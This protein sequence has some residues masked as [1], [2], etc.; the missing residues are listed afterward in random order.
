MAA[1]LKND[2]GTIHINENVIAKVCGMA[3]TDCM[4]VLGLA[5]ADG[6]SDL[7]KRD[8]IDKGVRVFAEESS[9]R[10]EMSVI[11]K[12]GVS[13]AAVAENIIDN[14]RFTIEN[15]VGISVSRVD[16]IV[17]GIRV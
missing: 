16:V 10:V 5:S 13:I 12:Y 17:R 14:V 6:I 9:V 4:G 8:S 2:F 15:M 1:V 3:A 11:V 7:L